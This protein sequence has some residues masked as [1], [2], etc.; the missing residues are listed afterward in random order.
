MD[1]VAPTADTGRPGPHL[2][3]VLGAQATGKSALTS[4]LAESLRPEQV[5]A[6][7]ELDALAAM[8][9]PEVTDWSSVLQ[10]WARTTAAW[11]DDGVDLVIAEGGS[12]AD[13]AELVRSCAPPGTEV[14]LLA[15]TCPLPLAV[16]RAQ[17]DPSRGISRDPEFLRRAHEAFARELPRLGPDLVLDTGALPM[18]D[19]VVRARGLL[20]A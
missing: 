19:A 17:A 2:L 13:E 3:L 9:G 7:V 8:L 16:E 18:A 1:D 4:A 5:V 10:V 14:R 15:L 6:R 11:L 12:T 20:R